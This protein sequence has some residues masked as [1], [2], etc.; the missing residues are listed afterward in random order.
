[1]RNY[2]CLILPAVAVF[3]IFS[4][5]WCSK[6]TPTFQF[7]KATYTNQATEE[8]SSEF[9]GLVSPVEVKSVKETDDGFVSVKTHLKSFVV[10]PLKIEVDVINKDENRAIHFKKLGYDVYF[11]GFETLSV[12]TGSVCKSGDILG[13]LVGDELLIKIYKNECRVSLNTL[14]KLLGVIV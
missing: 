10:A 8:A 2:K 4:A 7:G 5:I 13:S 12:K 14:M 1:M 9:L 3:L 11:Y 6:I